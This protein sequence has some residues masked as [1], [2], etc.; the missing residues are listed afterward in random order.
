MW[1]LEGQATH[2]AE[3]FSKKYIID[4]LSEELNDAAKPFR[5]GNLGASF[6]DSKTKLDPWNDVKKLF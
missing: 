4:F 2:V 5:Y 3:N 6:F 1:K